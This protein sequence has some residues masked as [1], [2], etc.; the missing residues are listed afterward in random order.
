MNTNLSL[1]FAATG[2][3]PID[4][5]RFDRTPTLS[6]E[7]RSALARAVRQLGRHKQ[8]RRLL[9]TPRL[10]RLVA[11][12]LD[13]SQVLQAEQGDGYH[14]ITPFFVEMH[15]RDISFTISASPME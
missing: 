8:A 2:N 13:L 11:P 3:L 15:R 4:V 6:P 5:E 14:Q 10:H 9:A 12:L 1:A 7:E